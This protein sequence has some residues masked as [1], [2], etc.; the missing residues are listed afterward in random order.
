MKIRNGN[1]ET[2]YEVLANEVSRIRR[3]C[4]LIQLKLAVAETHKNWKVSSV[5]PS[6]SS[7]VYIGVLERPK[8]SCYRLRG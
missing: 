4:Q 7:L 3:D 8:P 2:I 1:G 6:L 5:G